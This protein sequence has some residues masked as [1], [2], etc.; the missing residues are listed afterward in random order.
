MSTQYDNIAEAYISG[1]ESFGSKREEEA[2]RFIIRS[3]PSSP[4]LVVLDAGC[5]HGVDINMIEDR[6][7]P[8][9]ISGI[10]SS[11]AMLAHAKKNVSNP[12][13]LFMSSYANTPFEDN[14]FDLIYSRYALHYAEQFDDI[15][16]EFARILKPGGKM[17]HIVHHPFRDV[18]LQ[19][20]K[21]YGHQETATL[22]L[23]DNKVPIQFPT[24]TLKQYLSQTFF[25]HFELIGFEEEQSPEEYE[26]TMLTPGFMGLHARRKKI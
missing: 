9:S 1:Q 21:H 16:T 13:N 10:D 14:T 23:Y 25:K 17:I 7:H 5:G 24:H 2:L 12:E 22:H 3:F 19:K 18:S 15:F 4:D 6:F 11:A 8:K 20:K 26:D